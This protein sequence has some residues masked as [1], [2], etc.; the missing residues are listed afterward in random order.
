MS[1]AV[2]RVVLGVLSALTI[3]GGAALV[4]MV[5][6]YF[7]TSEYVPEL[8][9]FGGWGTITGMFALALYVAG[10]FHG[11]LPGRIGAGIG[12]AGAGYFASTIIAALVSLPAHRGGPQ[13]NLE[14]GTLGFL[15]LV[16]GAFFAWRAATGRWPVE[17]LSSAAQER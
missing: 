11:P 7:G 8:T 5:V 16:A 17:P 14:D 15:W 3:I 13:G 4:V 9:E 12:L 6:V 2:S 10:A 1:V